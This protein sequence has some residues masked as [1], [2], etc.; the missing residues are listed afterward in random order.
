MPM[1]RQRYTYIATA[2]YLCNFSRTIIRFPSNLH[3][4]FY[5]ACP[6][7]IIASRGSIGIMPGLFP[8]SALSVAYRT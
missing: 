5:P 8:E 3:L 2:M 6:I 7:T 1:S 4:R